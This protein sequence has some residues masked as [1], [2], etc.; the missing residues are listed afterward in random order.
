MS[1]ATLTDILSVNMVLV[2]PRL[3]RTPDERQRFEGAVKAEVVQ[4]PS[5]EL[6]IGG[7]GH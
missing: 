3:L 5:L 1:E 7:A 6:G 2:G 4:A